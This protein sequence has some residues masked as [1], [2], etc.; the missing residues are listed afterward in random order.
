MNARV[1][2]RIIDRCSFANA[3]PDA[4]DVDSESSTADVLRIVIPLINTWPAALLKA[5]V[6]TTAV[7]LM[8]ERPGTLP[9]RRE[10]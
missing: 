6:L 3:D 8:A 1:A 7:S 9:V 2:G 5:F 10:Y 4:K